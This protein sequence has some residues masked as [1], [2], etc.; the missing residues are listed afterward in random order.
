MLSAAFVTLVGASPAMQALR[1]QIA[2][3]ADTD[4]AVLVEGETGTGKEL[5]ARQI[6]A[7]SRRRHGPFVALNCAALVETLVEADL[8]GIEPGTATGVRSRRGKFE[9]AHGG[10][11]F[12]DE[13]A[14]LAPTAQAKLLRTLEDFTIERVGGQDVRHVDV[15]LVAATN[16]ELRGL[17]AQGLFRADL[18]YR[19]N[20]VDIQVPPLRERRADILLLAR[21]FLE[22]CRATR[23]LD[24]SPAAAEAL[25]A[26]AWPGNVRELQRV[27]EHAIAL[28]ASDRIELGDLPAAIRGEFEEII[29]P[30]FA[31]NDTLRAW[32]S[33]YAQLVLERCGGNKRRACQVLGISYHTLRSYVRRRTSDIDM[34]LCA[35]EATAPRGAMNTPR[36]PV[37]EF[38]ACIESVSSRGDVRYLPRRPA[39]PRF[40]V[41]APA[42]E[43]P[44]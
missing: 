15:R 32:A 16:R 28:T 6:H 26:Y 18:F 13:V 14:D 25:Q 5:V 20:G 36:E 19:L 27:L 37:N 10:T 21:H 22:R 41:H 30:S 9:Q 1:E 44:K 4:F 23:V 11:L 12:L 38:A 34:A 35:A 7:Q 17:V 3:V 8:F 40:Q 42:S 2:R 31:Q 43:A 29:Q 39:L 33:R 24:L